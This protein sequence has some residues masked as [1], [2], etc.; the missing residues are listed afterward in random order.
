VKT[1]TNISVDLVTHSKAQLAAGIL[2]TTI[3]ELTASALKQ[4]IHER[5]VG[6]DVERLIKSRMLRKNIGRILK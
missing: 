6:D 1:H 2:Q 4:H 5:G 3:G